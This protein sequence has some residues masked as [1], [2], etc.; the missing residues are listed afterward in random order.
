M[1]IRFMMLHRRQIEMTKRKLAWLGWFLVVLFAAVLFAQQQT[2][3]AGQLDIGWKESG[4]T[5]KPG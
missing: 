4:S 2:S 1:L 5:N 3:A